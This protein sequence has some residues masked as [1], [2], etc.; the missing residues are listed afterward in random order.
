[1]DGAPPQIT[2]TLPDG[3]ERAYAPGVTAGEIAADIA[4]SLAKRAISATLDGR[5]VD[6]A[7]PLD[8]G[9][10]LA[11][12][13]MKDEAAS[14]ELIRHDLAHVMARAVQEIWPDTKV[15][16]GPRDR[17]RLVLRLRPRRPLH[18][19]G[20]RPNR[21][22]DAR[23]RRRPRPRAHRGL[24][25][26]A[27]PRP[28]R[29]TASPSRSSWSRPSPRTSR[30]ACTGTGTGRTSAAARTS[31]TP[32][33]SR[34][35]P[36]SSCASRA[37]TGA[38][39]RRA[40]SSSASTAWPSATARTLK[41]YLT[42]T[43]GGRAARPP[44]ARAARWTSSTC[45]RRRRARC[46]GTPTGWTMYVALQDYM[47]RQ[48]ARGGDTSRSTPP[49]SS[50]RSPL[51]GVRPLGQVSA[52]TCSSSRSR[53]STPARR[54][55]TRLKPMNC[56]CHVQVFNQGL[57]SYRDLPLRMAEFGACTRYE[58]SGA[59]HGLMRC[60]RLHPGRR[61]HL[62]HR[63]ADRG[64]SAPASSG[65]SRQIYADLGFGA[66]DIK[67]S[68]RPEQRIGSDESWDYVEGALQRAI[69]ST[70]RPLRDRPRR[71]RLLRTEAR[72]LPHRRHRPAVAVRHLPGGSRTCPS[73]SA[74]ATSARTARSHRPF[75]LHRAALRLLRALPR[76]SS[77]SSMPAGC[78]SGSRRARWWWRPSSR[79]PDGYVREVVDAAA[80]RRAC[81]PRPTRATRRSTTRSASTRSGSCP[82]SSPSARARSRSA[83]SRVRRLGEK[84]TEVAVARRDGRATRRPRP[85]RPTCAGRRSAS[86]S[87]RGG[88]RFSFATS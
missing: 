39:T 68:T 48:P 56:P 20:P 62:L 2:F 17:E 45:R 46:S 7:W 4:P 77:S 35:T 50:T 11:I 28:L 60:A 16:I 38:G 26:R 37:P 29:G 85:P 15:T 81:A 3:A 83:A 27:R 34:P 24:G 1:M 54:R 18:P 13:T 65:S 31:S 70:G 10:R 32:V 69:E 67:L 76:A 5:H 47:R 53:R 14:L 30:S 57:K 79:T 64:R 61:P 73:G 58:P 75:M 44:P 6:L 82:S 42:M 55:S 87:R 21:G 12:N 49:R 72:L 19:R 41:A 43:G 9:G 59:L 25:P 51:G 52:S 63:G 33:S 71:G 40:S 23:D 88:T 22:A 86:R 78:R 36:S 84:G 80:G 8:A 74:R 66:F